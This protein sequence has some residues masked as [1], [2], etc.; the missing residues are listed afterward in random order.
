MVRQPTVLVADD[1]QAILALLQ[2]VFA[3]DGYAVLT[4]VGGWDA[5]ER[6]RVQ[7]PDVIVLDLQLPDLDGVDVSW[8]LRTDPRTADIPIVVLSATAGAHPAAPLLPVNERVCK[9][10][11]LARLSQAVGRWTPQR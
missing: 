11:D 6:A 4:A 10:F 3:L 1:D 7:Q 2:Q 5:L 9:P 8:R